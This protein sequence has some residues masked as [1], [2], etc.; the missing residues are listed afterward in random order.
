VAV[1]AVD[2]TSPL[3][4]GSILG[5]KTRMARLASDPAAFVRP[6][7]SSGTLG[8]VA[9]RTRETMLLCE[10]AGHDVILVETVGVGQSETVV[11]DMVDF[12]LV[13]MLAGAGDELQGIKRG[14]L[15]IADLIAVNKA[16]GDNLEAARRA[17]AEYAAALGLL[18]PKC[19]AWTPQATCV[20]ALTG[21]GLDELWATVEQHHAALAASGDLARRRAAQQRRWMWE[22]IHE[23][24]R[25][26][27]AADDAAQALARGLE[28]EVEGGELLAPHAA[29][30]VLD[31]FLREG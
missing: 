18:R 10:A 6:S 27:L 20:S 19:A 16:D 15:E 5:D 30:R 3:S 4:G 2:P 24:L 9:A 28:A 31:T 12:F 11:E 13:L 14:V 7:P 23:G 25:A 22:E 1:L 26:R 29:R 17:R 8:G 21:D